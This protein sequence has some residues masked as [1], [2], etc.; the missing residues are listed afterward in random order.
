MQNNDLQLIKVAVVDDHKFIVESLERGINNSG[1]A[2]VIDRA[3]NIAGYRSML[4]R[5]IPDVLLLDV[6]LPDGNSIDFCPE[7]C[8]DYPK[9]HILMLTSYSDSTV[10][11]R[12]LALGANGYILK[13]SL[14][15]EIIEG[16]CAVADGKRFLCDEAKEILNQSAEEIVPLTRREREILALITEGYTCKE[17]ADKIFL[18]YQTVHDYYKYLRLKLGANNTAS[19]VRKA[20]EQK[21]V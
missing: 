14:I 6:S 11:S 13:N 1:L 17:I 19:L 16:I 21:L 10:I 8:K 18:S 3:Y 7:I 5:C 2:Q 15:E 12:A 9:V 4:K 20:I